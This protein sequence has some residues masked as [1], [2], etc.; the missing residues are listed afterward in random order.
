MLELLIKRR[1]GMQKK[2]VAIEY[3]EVV[4]KIDGKQVPFDLTSFFKIA[5]DMGPKETTKDFRGEKARVQKSS[6]CT[7]EWEAMFVRMRTRDLP[8]IASEDGDFKM[9]KLDTDDY[10]G[11]FTSVI[12]EYIFSENKSVMGIHR[13]IHAFTPSGIQEYINL[14]MK[15]EIE[16][17]PIIGKSRIDRIRKSKTLR[18]FEIGLKEDAFAAIRG[19]D[20][21]LMGV[22]N[23][24]ELFGGHTLHLK[25][26]MG[27]VKKDKTLNLQT[28][29]KIIEEAYTT[30][31][32]DVLKVG[33]VEDNQ[34]EN[35][36]L[37]EDRVIDYKYVSYDNDNPVDHDKV[38][39]K[40]LDA[41]RYRRDNNKLFV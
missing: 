19:T 3:F 37:L 15:S 29:K 8:G 23:S 18:T 41:Y 32:L 21:T 20:S 11:E 7:K 26:S 2:R 22:L 27:N 30:K 31:D 24:M 35:V 16:L 5:K 33:Y 13:N 28:S 10:V 36:D 25:V 39:D 6:T 9:I 4:T 1:M 40:M 17:L 38:F 34:V 14:V 12:Y